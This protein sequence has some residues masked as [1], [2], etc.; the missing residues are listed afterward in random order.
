MSMRIDVDVDADIEL[1]ID[2]SRFLVS[3]ISRFG[4]YVSVDWWLPRICTMA[5]VD[6]VWGY[7]AM[8]HKGTTGGF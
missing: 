5:H 3:S 4:R 2:I 8:I 7:M 1:D 6:M